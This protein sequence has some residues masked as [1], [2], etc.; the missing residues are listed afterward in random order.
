MEL[1]KRFSNLR[2]LPE[3]LLFQSIDGGRKV[4]FPALR[5]LDRIRQGIVAASGNDLFFASRLNQRPPFV[6]SFGSWAIVESD[7]AVFPDVLVSLED[8][9]DVFVA[10]A[11]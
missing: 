8:L 5:G 1:G 3:K 11:D 7:V 9:T 6:D 4:R 2:R 10:R